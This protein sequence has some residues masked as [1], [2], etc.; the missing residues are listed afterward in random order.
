[1]KKKLFLFL[2]LGINFVAQAMEKHSQQESIFNEGLLKKFISGWQTMN[3]ECQYH[4]DKSFSYGLMH[5]DESKL[6]LNKEKEDEF[7]R[8]IEV[9][10]VQLEGNDPQEKG[11]MFLAIHF[12][13]TLFATH[14]EKKIVKLKGCKESDNG[15]KIWIFKDN[16]TVFE[17]R[18]T[19]Q[20]NALKEFLDSCQEKINYITVRNIIAK[21]LNLDNAQIKCFG[22]LFNCAFYLNYCLFKV[23]SFL[24]AMEEKIGKQ[25][26]CEFLP[27][28][29]R[30]SR[31]EKL[32][33]LLLIVNNKKNE[34]LFDE[35]VGQIE[36][37]KLHARLR[38]CE[39]I[40]STK[41]N[42]NRG[43]VASLLANNRLEELCEEKETD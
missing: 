5:S 7:C 10:K 27:A 20:K 41:A 37:Q 15:H 31:L 28:K 21:N 2:V 36:D 30:S 19:V 1:M 35:V 4:D 13:D 26:V 17:V 33:W 6:G 40:I 24:C 18:R 9:A 3:E 39:I 43:R 8:L 29:D 38:K 12:L 11:R 42:D 32:M 22:S 16:T 25:Q 34:K 23:P 14:L